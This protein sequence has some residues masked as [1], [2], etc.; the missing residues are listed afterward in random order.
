LDVNSTTGDLTWDAVNTLPNDSPDITGPYGLEINGNLLYVTDIT[1][2]EIDIYQI[3]GNTGGLTYKSSFG[4]GGSGKDQFSSP[5]NLDFFT[6]TGGQ[7]KAFVP[8][9]NNKRIVALNVTSDLEAKADSNTTDEDH[10]LTV[11]IPGVLGNDTG[12][13]ITVT[14][15]DKTSAKGATVVVN[16]NGFYSYDPTTAAAIQAL[17]AGETSTDSFNYTIKNSTNATASAKVTINLTGVN[18]L[19]VA[20]AINLEPTNEDAQ[21]SY[22]VNLLSTAN[23]IDVSDVLAVADVTAAS[24]N[25]GRT[26]NFAINAGVLSLDPNQFNNLAV[27]ETETVTVSY[28]VSDGKGGITP[29]TATFTVEGRNDAPVAS[30]IENLTTNEDAQNPYTV[31]LLSTAN[32]I[33]VSDVLAVADITAASDNPGRTVNFAINA[34]VLSLDPNQFN[35]LA[36][37]NE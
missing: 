32:D 27:G 34:G 4:S 20:S 7:T 15:F 30:A 6:T 11:A 28:K 25:P 13:G 29:N 36:L 37:L 3:N 16:P 12:D 8:D 14:A 33:D 9:H 23:D 5:V 2:H 24:D 1:G 19:P 18:D 21:N 26:V 10:D 22:T 17:G 35:N 31:N